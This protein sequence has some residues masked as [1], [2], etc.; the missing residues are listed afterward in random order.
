LVKTAKEIGAQVDA[1][2]VAFT[3]ATAALRK[4]YDDAV[5]GATRAARL[6]IHAV[7][8]PAGGVAIALRELRAPG[9]AAGDR[10]E[11]YVA[12]VHASAALAGAIFTAAAPSRDPRAMLDVARGAGELRAGNHA[13]G[14]SALVSS[15]LWPEREPFSSAIRMSELLIGIASATTTEE[16][17]SHIEAA[18]PRP[19]GWQRKRKRVTLGLGAQ[20]GLAGGPEWTLAGSGDHRRERGSQIEVFIPVGFDVAGPVGPHSLGLL[21]QV[22]DLGAVSSLRFGE[23]EAERRAELEL[24]SVFAPGALLYLGLGQSPFTLSVGGSYVAGLRQ[25]GDESRADVVRLQ[26]ALAVDLPLFAF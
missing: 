15:G 5:D 6:A 19:R 23:G 22:L 13:A 26:A 3:A 11:L 17:A 2:V 18:A 25:R 7:A 24:T 21:L 1:T 12:A 8:G 9:K 10:R 16:M 20:F 4:A 14:F